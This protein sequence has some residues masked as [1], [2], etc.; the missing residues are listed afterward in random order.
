MLISMALTDYLYSMRSVLIHSTRA[1]RPNVDGN[2][3]HRGDMEID[4]CGKCKNFKKID[5]L[6]HFFLSAWHTT[7][8]DIRDSSQSGTGVEHI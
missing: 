1:G 7:Q 5:E 3:M 4:T 2:E 6:G 8:Y